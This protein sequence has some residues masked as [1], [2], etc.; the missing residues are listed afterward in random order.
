MFAGVKWERNVLAVSQ[1]RG[2]EDEDESQQCGYM[3]MKCIKLEL[4]KLELM[5]HDQTAIKWL[6][7][8]DLAAL[9][10]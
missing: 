6:N 10:A 1:R 8:D 9:T 5:D 3:R 2:F 7:I 4:K